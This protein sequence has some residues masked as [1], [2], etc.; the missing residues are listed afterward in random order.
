MGQKDPLKYDG[1][2]LL[3]G[4]CGVGEILL[5]LETGALPSG[6]SYTIIIVKY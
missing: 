2:R 5:H 1:Q 3:L 4:Q 6:S